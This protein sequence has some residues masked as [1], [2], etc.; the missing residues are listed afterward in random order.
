M[1]PEYANY[2]IIQFIENLRIRIIKYKSYLY[3][4]N[5]YITCKVQKTPGKLMGGTDYF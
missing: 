4:N 3:I 5:Y 2:Y 1:K